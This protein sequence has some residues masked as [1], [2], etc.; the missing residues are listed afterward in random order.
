MKELVK[1]DGCGNYA[2]KTRIKT[3]DGKN[4]CPHC[5]NVTHVTSP[6]PALPHGNTPEPDKPKNVKD[7]DYKAQGKCCPC[8]GRVVSVEAYERMKTKFSK[9][10]GLFSE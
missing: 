9:Y 8:C 7:I 1:C 4:L 2:H 6:E 10:E 3:I 5:A